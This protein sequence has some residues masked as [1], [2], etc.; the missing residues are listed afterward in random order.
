MITSIISLTRFMKLRNL[1][2]PLAALVIAAACFTG[3]INLE[4]K[5]VLN[6]DGSGTMKIHYWS[7]ISN[8][9][10]SKEL[11]GFSFDESRAK[12]NYSS[13][14]IDVLSAKLEEKLDDSTSHVRVELKFKNIND[15]KTARGFDRIKSSW[16]EGK[17]GMEF[18]YSIPQDSTASEIIGASV[19]KIIYEF[20]FPGEVL[21]TNGTKEGNKVVWNKSLADLKTELV[22]T[23]TVEPG[24][25]KCGLFGVEFPLLALAGITAIALGSKRKK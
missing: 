15:L 23:A 12:T 13:A 24:G 4:Q 7:K 16:K 21:E 8:I 3:C 10:L 5:T 22:L 11:G 14:N 25:K 18:T 19:Y 17:E 9:S 2:L 1:I 6:R 20:E